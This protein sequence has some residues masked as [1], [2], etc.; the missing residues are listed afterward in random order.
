M[1]VTRLPSPGCAHRPPGAS[2][3][4]YR[5]Y[6]HFQI[7]SFFQV[8]SGSQLGFHDT[9]SPRLLGGTGPAGTFAPIA[10]LLE[11][12]T[13]CG[14]D[15]TGYCLSFLAEESLLPTHAGPLRSKT[16]LSLAYQVSCDAS[17]GQ[18]KRIGSFASGI[19]CTRGSE[20]TRC[21]LAISS[22][23]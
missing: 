20:T 1:L 14:V 23:R 19:G 2:R 9:K 15:L 8:L 6:F 10:P 11:P 18:G 7:S 21:S 4:L 12:S 16:A 17:G 3:Q 22:Q 13:V 5:L